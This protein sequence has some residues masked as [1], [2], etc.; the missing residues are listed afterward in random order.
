MYSNGQWSAHLA[1][2]G[3]W[4]ITKRGVQIAT[5]KWGQ[6]ARELVDRL[7]LSDDVYESIDD[8]FAPH[9]EWSDELNGRGM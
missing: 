7:A 1:D 8:L 2:M 6:E 4:R 3:F 5:C 9:D